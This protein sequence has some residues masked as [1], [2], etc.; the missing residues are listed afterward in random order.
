MKK[1]SILF[2]LPKGKVRRDNKIVIK[3]RVTYDKNRKEFSTG[4]FINPDYWDGKSQEVKNSN[5]SNIVNSQ[6]NLIKTK[7]N[8]VF[9]YLQVNDTKFTVEDILRKYKG[10]P[11]KKEFGIVEVYNNYLLRIEKLVGKDIQ[12]VTYNK[13]I[14]S[15]RHLKAFLK[16]KYKQK[17]ILVLELKYPFITEY[18]YFLKT[19]Q[20]LQ[21]STLNKAIQRFRKVISFAISQGYLDRD[22]FY[23]Y[24]A[25]RLKKEV[26]FLN[27]NQLKALECKNFE[28][29]RLQQIKDMFVFCCYTGLGFKEM[30]GLKYSNI[31][32]RFDGN[33]WLSVKRNKTSRVYYVPILPIA[34]VLIKKYQNETDYVFP[35]MSNPKFNAYLKEIANVVGIQLNLTHHIAR[36]T[37]ATTVLLYND[38]PME[39]VSELLGHSKLST[40][41]EHY[42]KVV[43]KKVSEQMNSLSE[44]LNKN[45]ENRK[46]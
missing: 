32:E 6:L 5:G 12:L 45:E 24:K 33:E 20:N 11:T 46:D 17:D 14:E 27:S 8:Q 37:F 23:A 22:P 7:I 18:E 38:V 44:K 21:L 1:L 25:K 28:I 43:Q 13:Y 30:M 2:I 3:C 16:S 15:L 10:E 29:V 40:T 26:V 36:K 4:I 9:L 35:R 34:K 31:I 39:V 19:E 42:A 41:Q